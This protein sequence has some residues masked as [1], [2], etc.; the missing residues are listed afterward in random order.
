[1]VIL[2][3]AMRLR[4]AIQSQKLLAKALCAENQDARDPDGLTP[5]QI[6]GFKIIRMH[7]HRPTRHPLLRAN[8]LMTM[9]LMRENGGIWERPVDT[10][11]TMGPLRKIRRREDDAVKR[12]A[13]RR[14][15]WRVRREVRAIDDQVVAI[16]VLLIPLERRALREESSVDGARRLQVYKRCISDFDHSSG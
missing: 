8:Q 3:L 6:L 7:H 15:L 10:L 9:L 5:A 2:I 14:R 11:G 1:M 12:V 16:L 13:L 4:R